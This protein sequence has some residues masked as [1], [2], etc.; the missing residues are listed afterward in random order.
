MP[1]AEG[2]NLS[3][4]IRRLWGPLSTGEPEVIQNIQPV[5]VIGDHSGL[6]SPLYTAEGHAQAL[7]PFSAGM[8]CCE[9]LSKAAGGTRVRVT[10][11]TTGK[12]DDG[13]LLAGAAFMQYDFR[14]V[15]MTMTNSNIPVIANVYPNRPV[16][17]FIRVGDRPF[18]TRNL[19]ADG[20][21]IFQ[22]DVYWVDPVTPTVKAMYRG[23]TP[24]IDVHLPAG[25]FLWLESYSNNH[26]MIFNIILEEFAAGPTE[27][28]T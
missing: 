27:A 2:L 24:Q 17:T 15:P 23:G 18:A 12:W 19:A 14:D 25:R 22:V 13:L 4:W 9:V 10:V 3:T 21:P 20:F 8:S 11:A 28:T 26:E 5:L 7:Q 6:V 1:R 16:S